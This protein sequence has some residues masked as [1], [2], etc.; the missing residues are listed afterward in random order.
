M[1]VYIAVNKK[2]ASHYHN[3]DHPIPK[4]IASL[5]S[6]FRHLSTFILEELAE[7]EIDAEKIR[8]HVWSLPYNLKQVGSGTNSEHA[9]SIEQKRS[10]VDRLFAYLDATIWN[11]IDYKLLEHITSLF[12]SSKLQKEMGAYISE[13]STFESEVMISEL[14]QH[15]PGRKH[16]PS[17]YCELT[18]R[19]DL[20]PDRC[21]LRRLNSL[22]KKVCDHFLPPLAELA[23]LHCKLSPGRVVEVVWLVARD[24]IP[25]LTNGIVW[26]DKGGAFFDENMMQS[27]HIRDVLVY[28][29][30]INGSAKV[31]H[32]LTSIGK[33]YQSRNTTS[34]QRTV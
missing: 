7:K 26:Q 23:F 9:Q 20:D 31:R 30:T 34:L 1:G 5:E 15:W 25:S 32:N 12:G 14:V 24:L 13:I 17:T 22:R 8:K 11:F 28:P 2:Q 29:L 3:L 16:T 27:I 4:K 21:T 6:K 33:S 18:T 10:D 19:F